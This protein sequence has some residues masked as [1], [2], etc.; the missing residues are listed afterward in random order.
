MINGVESTEEYGSI[1]STEE[2]GCANAMDKQMT[3]QQGL[4][5]GEVCDG[6]IL[7]LLVQFAQSMQLIEQVPLVFS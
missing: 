5:H 4:G 7:V 3:A 2:F 6:Q 1:K